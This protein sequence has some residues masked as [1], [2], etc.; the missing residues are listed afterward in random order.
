MNFHTYRPCGLEF[1][2]LAVQIPNNNG[3]VS[4]RIDTR[5]M[6]TATHAAE[7]GKETS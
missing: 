7:Y 3:G 4:K 6:Y 1:G 2:S 5:T